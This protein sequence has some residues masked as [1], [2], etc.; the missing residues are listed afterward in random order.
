MMLIEEN[1]IPDAVLPVDAFKAHLRLGTGFAEDSLQEDVL[2]SFLRAAIAAIEAR[3]G[4]AL[5]ERSFSLEL[6]SWQNAM[7]QSIPVAPVVSVT[8]VAVL[9]RLGQ[10]TTLDPESYWVEQDAHSPRLKPTGMLL[11]S[12]PQNGSARLVFLAGYAP[13]FS[14]VPSDLVQAVMML[15]AHYYEF[16]NDTALSSGCMP[17][18]V[19]SL[20]ERYRSLRLH[21]GRG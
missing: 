18:G 14:G 19:S 10:A 13:D 3:T 6:N 12:L 5:I 4:K 16:R 2:R 15:A 9:D 11:P 8:S 1:T 20:V 7:G 17:F 21:A